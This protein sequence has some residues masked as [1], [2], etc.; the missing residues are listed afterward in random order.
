VTCDAELTVVEATELV[1]RRIAHWQNFIREYTEDAQ[2]AAY[3]ILAEL[4]DIAVILNR[5]S[6]KPIPDREAI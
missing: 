1:N 6:N 5:Y 3:T 4:D 2:V